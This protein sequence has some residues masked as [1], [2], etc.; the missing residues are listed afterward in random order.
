MAQAFRAAPLAP[1]APVDGAVPVG[2]LETGIDGAISGD[3]LAG[4]FWLAVGT[5]VSA[6]DVGAK[7]S[8]AL[9]HAASPTADRIKTRSARIDFWALDAAPCCCAIRTETPS[10][11]AIAVLHS[12]APGLAT[13]PGALLA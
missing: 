7:V 5:L 3:A 11:V 1:G 6:V 4:S 2:W 9:P 8:E 12:N 10:S 13:R